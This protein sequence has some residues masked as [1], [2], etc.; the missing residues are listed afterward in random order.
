[1]ISRI[2]LMG[3]KFGIL[4]ISIF[5]CANDRTTSNQEA[6]NGIDL[7]SSRDMEYKVP[8]NSVGDRMYREQKG[9]FI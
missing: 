8:E 4:I 2:V 9:K 1:M 5:Q 7:I 6:G 3:S